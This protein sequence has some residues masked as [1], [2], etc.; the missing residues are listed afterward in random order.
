VVEE[1][2][3]KQDPVPEERLVPICCLEL[4][5]RACPLPLVR[6]DPHLS[7]IESVSAALAEHL[8]LDR[9]QLLLEEIS[10]LVQTGG[11]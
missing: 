3:L 10:L 1:E 7:P 6:R 4:V 5:R 2:S 8:L 9:R 11:I